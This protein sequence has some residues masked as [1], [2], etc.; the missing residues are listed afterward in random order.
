MQKEFIPSLKNG[1]TLIDSCYWLADL[2]KHFNIP[3]IVINHKK[4]GEPLMS[5]KT[6]T[7]K[8]FHS[9]I[10][11]FSCLNDQATKQHI[12]NLNKKQI[13]LAGAESHI[14]ILQSAYDFIQSGYEVF[15]VAD[16]IASRN[17]ID[18]D[19]SITRLNNLKASVVTKE[20][21]FFEFLRNSEYPN[22]IDLSLKFLDGRYIR[23]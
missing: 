16:A 20:M 13:I 5:L 17:Q 19:L 23:E 14:S 7:S 2:A 4:L 8:E 1:Q 10:I 11:D 22:Y 18:H 21:V 6:L 12:K 9:E 3:I 15:I